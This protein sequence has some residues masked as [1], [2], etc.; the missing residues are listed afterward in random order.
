M[1]A[2]KGGQG[3]LPGRRDWHQALKDEHGLDKGE[4]SH[5]GT[6]DQGGNKQESDILTATQPDLTLSLNS[7][8][9]QLRGLGRASGLNVLIFKRR[10]GEPG[11]EV[12]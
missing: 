10:E 5:R 4:E 1:G 2:D 6:D 11:A 12:G 8:S 9:Y 3:G 7:A